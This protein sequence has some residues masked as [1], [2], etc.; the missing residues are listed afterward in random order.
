MATDVIVGAYEETIRLDVHQLVQRLNSH[1]GA[2]LVA[3]LAGVRDS[4]LPYR[5]A[6]PDGP[7]PGAAAQE[8]LQAAHRAWLSLA[9]AD[10]DTVARAWFVGANPL[11]GE[12][13]PVEVL[14]EG[15]TRAV[16]DAMKS[17]I[18]GAWHG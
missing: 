18:E 6:K 8:R 7:V 3:V 17:F 4:K 1:L 15:D 16:L 5:W 2:T 9:D 14:R 12:K 13:A 10:S 11:L